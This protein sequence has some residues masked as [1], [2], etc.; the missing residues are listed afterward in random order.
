MRALL[1]AAAL[2]GVTASDSRDLDRALAG[3]APGKPVACVTGSR[4]DSPQVIG[5]T[6]LLYRDGDRV[7]RNDLPSACP[8]LD[9]DAI[10]VSEIHGGQMCRNDRFYT[11][12][13]GGGGIPG[14]RCRLGD[15]VP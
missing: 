7:W 13:R 2:T 3:R 14:A 5:D 10:V 4:I 12:R 1:I 15:F 11:L 8:G 6:T 9:D